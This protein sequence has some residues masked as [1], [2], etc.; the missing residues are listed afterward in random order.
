MSPERQQFLVSQ[1]WNTMC[2]IVISFQIDYIGHFY[3]SKGKL[4]TASATLKM[5]VNNEST[6]V[7]LMG[8]LIKKRHC[9]K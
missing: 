8:L 9:D 5:S 3:I 2:C 6:I 1:Y 7:G 4:H